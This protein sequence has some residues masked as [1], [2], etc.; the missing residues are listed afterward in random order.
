MADRTGLKVAVFGL[1]SMGYGIASSILRAGHTVYGFDVVPEAMTR[2]AADGGS[3]GEL[4]EVAPTLDAVVV[5]VLNAEQTEAVLFGDAGVVPMLRSGAVVLSCATVAPEFAREKA[6]QCEAHQ[7][8]YLD[9]PI[10]G[11][12]VKAA[13]GQLS[14]MASGSRAS[15][16]AA[17]PILDA[18]AETVF[19]M[20]DEAGA[21]SVMKVVNQLLAGVHIATMAEAITFGM[22]QGL[23]RRTASSR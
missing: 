9:A 6:A 17:A 15:F 22:K 14:I 20:G 13:A 21:G 8:R 18:T 11:G 4:A 12:S 5:V 16:E 19:N 23:A 7:I 3:P 2:F 1:G 10:S